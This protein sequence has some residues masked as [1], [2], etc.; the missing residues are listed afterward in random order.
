MPPPEDHPA[1]TKFVRETLAQARDTARRNAEIRATA[2][3]LTVIAEDLCSRAQAERERAQELASERLQR[4]HTDA[5]VVQLGTG[6]PSQTPNRPSPSRAGD[7]YGDPPVIRYLRLRRSSADAGDSRP[8]P[9][10]PPCLRTPTQSSGL[11]GRQS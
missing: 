9:G 2:A 10:L 6:Q 1:L 5:V 7:P 4:C 8:T 3:E 11:A